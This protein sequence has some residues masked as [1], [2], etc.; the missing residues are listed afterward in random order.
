MFRWLLEP[1]QG[2][3]SPFE[4]GLPVFFEPTSGLTGVIGV[5]SKIGFFFVLPVA[6]YFGYTFLRPALPSPLQHG[7]RLL[8]LGFI[9]F[10]LFMSGAA[11]AFYVLLPNMLAFLIGIADGVATPMVS[12]KEYTALLFTMTSLMGMIF[13]V[14]VLMFLL[15]KWRITSYNK[16]KGFRRRFYIFAIV[17]SVLITPTFDG[18]TMSLVAL[19]LAAVY[20]VGLLAAWITHPSEGDYLFLRSLGRAIRR[21][22]RVVRA[23]VYF[24]YTGPRWLF[25]KVF[26]R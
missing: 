12:L 20:E 21:V 10:T 19:P 23:I 24:P 4:G 25:R 3:L 5:A 18:V 22:F 1:A 14:P 6:F 9:V 8:L 11:F 2:R 16:F 15:A 17:F 13:L 7:K 26:K